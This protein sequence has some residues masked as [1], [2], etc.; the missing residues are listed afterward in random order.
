MSKCDLEVLDFV[1]QVLIV[2]QVEI[3]TT[4]N[5]KLLII[6]NN[7]TFQVTNWQMGVSL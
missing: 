4:W 2:Y 6:I 7:F 3:F 5:V 1:E